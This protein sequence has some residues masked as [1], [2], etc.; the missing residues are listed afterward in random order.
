M[1]VPFD[2]HC[3]VPAYRVPSH[4]WFGQHDSCIDVAFLPRRSLEKSTQYSVLGTAQGTFNLSTS[5]MTQPTYACH[6]ILLSKFPYVSLT[7]TD[8][9]R[10]FFLRF[11]RRAPKKVWGYQCLC[12]STRRLDHNQRTIENIQVKL[13]NLL[14]LQVFFLTFPNRLFFFTD[15]SLTFLTCDIPARISMWGLD[16]AGLGGARLGEGSCTNYVP[17]CR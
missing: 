17:G 16:A 9:I 1:R 5:T 6:K 3:T 2:P 11:A 14:T 7:F 10:S 8:Q 15:F 4:S 12:L 13:E